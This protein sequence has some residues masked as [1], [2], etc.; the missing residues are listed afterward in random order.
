MVKKL[1]SLKFQATKNHGLFVP[2]D[3]NRPVTLRGRKG[4]VESMRKHGFLPYYPIVCKRVNWTLQIVDGQHRL[5]AAQVLGIPVW[6]VVVRESD[7]FNVAE[8]NAEQKPWTNRDY[9]ECFAAMDGGNKHYQAVL[10]FSKTYHVAVS[11]A[12]GVLAGVTT[13]HI[14]R[15]S[16]K[17]GTFQIASK[18]F[19]AEVL[20]LYLELGALESSIKGQR[21]LTACLAVCKWSG[22]SGS[23]LLQGAKRC[24]EKLV[25]Y[26]T[27]DAFLGMFEELYNYGRAKKAAL[28]IEALNAINE[29]ADNEVS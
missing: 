29:D 1:E 19:A 11:L 7:D 8:V 27:R 26:G 3:H 17:A 21:M 12:A 15:R 14:V 28:R 20:T 16:F 23:R 2:S 25:P 9:A 4:L 24:R 13:F 22:F 6:Y 10:D 5:A 18:T